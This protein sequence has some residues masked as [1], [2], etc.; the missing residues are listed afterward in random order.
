VRLL[1]LAGKAR[2]LAL[3]GRTPR[4]PS[5]G[6]QAPLFCDGIDKCK[7]GQCSKHAGGGCDDK[8]TCTGTETCNEAGKR[9][10]LAS[11]GLALAG[12]D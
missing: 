3:A 4:Q 2:P 5:P 10:S 6:G 8:V 1:V 12:T 9:C 7:A 11:K